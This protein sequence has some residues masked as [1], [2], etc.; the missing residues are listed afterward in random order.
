MR[1]SS[2]A[3]AIQADLEEEF[4]R[5]NEAFLARQKER[6]RPFF[7]AVEANPL[8]DE[9][10][11]ACVC[12]DD[13][14][15]VVAAAGSG[16]SS[17]MVAKA[18]YALRERLAAG[19]QILM[20][21]FNRDASGQLAQRVKRRLADVGGA[22]AI[23]VKTFHAFS[24]EIIAAATGEKP[25]LAPWVGNPEAEAKVVADIAAEL[26]EADPGFRRDWD[27]FRTVFGRDINIG[28][29]DASANERPIYQSASGIYVRSG[30]ERQIADWLFYHSVPFE[31][32]RRY[33]HPTGDER[34]Y[35]PDFYY[36]S[37]G[38][39]HEHFAVDA[40]GTSP[41]GD[42]YLKGVTWKRSEHANRGTDLFETTSAQFSD[43][44][45]LESLKAELSK[46]GAEIRFDPGRKAPGAKPLTGLEL[47]GMMRVFQRHAKG[48]C[49]AASQIR[50]A[51]AGR[52]GAA[53][54]ARLGLFLRLYERISEGWARR[55]HEADGID[56]EDM[57]LL[58]AD[59]AESGRYVSPFTVVLVDEF[60]DTSK[61][62]ARLLKALSAGGAAHLC[63]VGDDW[64]AVNRFAGGDLS[65]MT[66]FAEQF[67]H[68]TRLTLGTTFR[69]PQSLCD[70]SSAFVLANPAQIRK[71]VTTQSGVQGDA[72]AAFALEDGRDAPH[73]LGERIG[74]LHGRILGGKPP[75]S[76]GRRTSVMVLGRYRRDRPAELT[77]WQRLY[78]DLIDIEFRTVHRSKGAEADYVA[79][80]N[81][82][83]DVMGFPSQ[84]DDDPVLL[85]AMPVPDPFP[86]A[87][88]RRLFYVALT[89]A[90]RQVWI[91]AEWSRRS[92]FLR[93]LEGPGLTVRRRPALRN[94][95]PPA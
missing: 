6:L 69:C 19:H 65:V 2:E 63:A 25:R 31:Y 15:L 78:G 64:Q 80:L 81:V 75:V 11:E 43:G 62:R 23:C 52:A 74:L 83:E 38:L 26:S 7:D 13:S 45:A 12:M 59:Y 44:T 3:P 90:R 89:R 55:L 76:E 28:R 34:Q 42:E 58:A 67:A 22:E 30:Q 91:Y 70:A 48:N 9:Q 54:A 14:V 17:T 68:A 24:L 5:H 73:Y 4:R 94:F 49:M 1:P 61:V 50:E 10:I 85:A 88:E 82:V 57:I 8:T 39:Y 56:F 41:F 16:K 40:D 71:S 92:R 32:E 46:S 47:A 53:D 79:L 27:L 60:Q 95:G 29:P 66:N 35:R 36:P 93:E 51:A 33:E 77:K 18:G 87:E 72:L 86:M 84:I 20:L 37:I 21:A